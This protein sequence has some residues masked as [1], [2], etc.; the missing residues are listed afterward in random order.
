[1]PP[2]ADDYWSAGFSLPFNFCFYGSNYNS[3]LVGTN[4]VITF[5]TVNQNAGGYCNW[6]FTAS[7][8]AAAFPI[9][10]AIYGVYQDTNI[11]IPP[12]TSPTVQNVNYYIL[13]TGVNAAP[14]RVF[15]A[16]F[17]ELPQYQ[18]NSS[19]GLQSSQ[20]ILYEGTNTID[21]LVKNRTSCT[22]WNSGSGLIGIQNLAGTSATTP[23]GRNTGAWSAVNEAWRFS[24]NGAS[25]ASLQW[26]MNGA[27]FT[28]SNPAT[29]CISSG[30][31]VAATVSYTDCASGVNTFTTDIFL[32][33]EPAIPAQDPMDLSACVENSTTAVFDL[34]SNTAIILGAL[35]PNDYIVEY[36]NTLAEAMNYVNPIVNVSNY[37]SSGETIYVRI[38]GFITGCYVTKSFTLTV[39][40]SPVAPTGNPIQSFMPGETLANIEL[41]GTNITWYTQATNGVQLS[42]S[43]ELQHGV[44]YYAS[45]ISAAGCESRIAASD[46][47]AVTVYNVLSNAGWSLKD[48]TAIPNPVRDYLY[49]SYAKTISSVAIFNV[50]GQQLISKDL[51]DNESKVDMSNFANGTYMVKIN[52]DNQQKVIKVVKE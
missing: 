41:T 37:D 26:S 25:T 20:I 6:P 10:N 9:K 49:I 2:S 30:S 11:S 14:N 5:D 45:Q 46:R 29:V 8:P 31:V 34:S 43:T 18:C 4:G 13:N 36:F 1:M 39:N 33:P 3:I 22:S 44:T 19:V 17:N 52:A 47:F 42:S 28:S 51:N 23:P 15:V 32:Q 16:N 48:L 35:N 27:P 12:V 40:P 7:I 24:P 21:V 38:E 50:L